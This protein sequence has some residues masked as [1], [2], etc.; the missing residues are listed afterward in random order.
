[1]PPTPRRPWIPGASDAL[2]TAV[3]RGALVL[4]AA[5]DGVLIVGRDGCIRYVNAAYCALLEYPHEEL[6]GQPLSVLWLEHASLKTA[7]RAV[8]DIVGEGGRVRFETLHRC[9]AGR[10]VWVEV[11]VAE[12]PENGDL[13]VFARDISERKRLD[14]NE[15]ARVDQRVGEAEKLAM[16]LKMSHEGV[17]TLDREGVILS[18]NDTYCAMMGYS[19]EQLVGN[20]LARF[21]VST[22]DEAAVSRE[23]SA[24]AEGAGRDRFETQHRHHDGHAFPVEVG[25]AWLPEY[26]EFVA[27]LRDITERKIRDEANR[28]A[29]FFDP[30]TQLPNRRMLMDRFPHAASRSARHGTHGALLFLDLDRFKVVND[31]VG[32]EAGDALLREVARR[33]V[34]AVRTEDSVVRLGGD[35][36]VVLVEGLPATVSDAVAQALVVAERVRASLADAYRFGAHVHPG[37][38]SVGLALFRGASEQMDD[39]LRRADA[40][41]YS[42]KQAGGCSVRVAL[43]S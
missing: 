9:K 2:A 17:C 1:M 16:I 40:A 19:R 35:E 11:S 26:G 39:V 13:A 33:L 20:P 32:H 27:F 29:A 12:L 21:E 10:R 4:D 37:G 43:S 36:F 7:Q 23:L 28:K 3:A 5:F 8:E 38:C 6:V 14:Q 31:T 34:S 22:L 18:V 24:I 25:L 42:A 30:L 41:M 15:V